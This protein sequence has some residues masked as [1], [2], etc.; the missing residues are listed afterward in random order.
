MKT[1]F[2][3]L[4]VFVGCIFSAQGASHRAT[5]NLAVLERQ[6]AFILQPFIQTEEGLE[7]TFIYPGGKIKC[8]ALFSEQQPDE[9]R[10]HIESHTLL[11]NPLLCECGKAF[12]NADEHS[13]H[14]GEKESKHKRKSS[15]PKD[16]QK[17]SKTD[18]EEATQKTSD[19]LRST[20]TTLAQDLEG[21]N[22]EEYLLFCQEFIAGSPLD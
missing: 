20:E 18:S 3:R 10:I 4:L 15:Q 8:D 13:A 1:N 19:S 11:T 21:A 14:A 6:R 2:P 12:R 5:P 9:M 16:S 17:K 7:C 22:D